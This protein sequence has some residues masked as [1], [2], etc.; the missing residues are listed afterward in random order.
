MTV[1]VEQIDFNAGIYHHQHVEDFLEP[2][3][4]DL[5]I[6]DKDFLSDDLPGQVAIE[7][8]NGLLLIHIRGKLGQDND[9]YSQQAKQGQQNEGELG[10]K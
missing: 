5:L 3:A 6:L 2:L 9:G 8:L 10:I 4:V 1:R 7:L